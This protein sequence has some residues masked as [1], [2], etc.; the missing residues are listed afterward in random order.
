MTEIFSFE[1]PD[2]NPLNSDMWNT[3]YKEGEDFV[4]GDP[5]EIKHGKQIYGTVAF[6]GKALADV[7][8]GIMPDAWDFKGM[9]VKEYG[10]QFDDQEAWEKSV[11]SYA[12]RLLKY[13]ITNP[14]YPKTLWALFIFLLRHLRMPPL[15][16]EVNQLKHM[17]EQL[18]E[19]LETG[20]QS[21]RIIA[22]T[23][24]PGEDYQHTDIP[25]LQVVQVFPL[26]EK[27][28]STRYSFRSHDWGHGIW[29][30]AYY[31]NNGILKHVIEPVGGRLVETIFTSNVAH[32]YNNDFSMVEKVIV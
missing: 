7:N 2:R 23:F 10:K 1:N 29:P 31:L 11:Y 30:N 25:C 19:C 32:L 27:K 20:I 18:K 17:R 16:I 8:A 3:I 14:D 22:I 6:R 26:G 28:V 9:A 21:T 13:E 12:K 5:L 4:F 15:T 24:R